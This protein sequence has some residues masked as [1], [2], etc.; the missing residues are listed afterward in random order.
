MFVLSKC[1]NSVGRI[2]QRGQLR[3]KKGEPALGR[4]KLTTPFQESYSPRD[5]KNLALPKPL[6]ESRPSRVIST[7]A[8][9]F[10]PFAEQGHHQSLSRMTYY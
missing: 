4:Q 7:V 6:Y 5:S 1:N 3:N 8:T 9:I 10:T 2:Y